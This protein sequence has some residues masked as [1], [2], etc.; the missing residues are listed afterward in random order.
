MERRKTRREFSLNH[1]RRR[2]PRLHLDVDWF[3]ESMGC[4]TLGRGLEISLRGALLPVTCLGQ[5]APDVT[6]HVA[7]PSRARMLKARGVAMS[8]RE[9]GW[10]IEFRSVAADDLHLLAMSLIE[11]HGVAAIPALERKYARFLEFEPRHLRESISPG[12]L[13]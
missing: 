11:H 10:A 1:T 6:L 13:R 12:A 7:L 2:Y 9:R 4:S 5:F 3:V 8:R